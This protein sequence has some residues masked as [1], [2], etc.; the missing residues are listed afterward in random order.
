[1]FLQQRQKLLLERH[2]AM[3]FLLPLDVLYDLVQLRNA[4]AKRAVFFLPPEETMFRKGIM[5]P[6]GRAAFNQLH[7]FGNR[8]CRRRGEQDMHVVGHTADLQA[9][10]LAVG[11]YKQWSDGLVDSWIDG[12]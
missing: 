6:F 7:R 1:M 12:S 8:H 2:F 4:H 11:T 3:M 10:T 9:E 5:H